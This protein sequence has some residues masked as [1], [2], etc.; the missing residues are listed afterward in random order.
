MMTGGVSNQTGTTWSAKDGT[1]AVSCSEG[2]NL[3]DIFSRDK[4]GMYE[5]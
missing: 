2:V 5:R 4:K 3:A 1:F